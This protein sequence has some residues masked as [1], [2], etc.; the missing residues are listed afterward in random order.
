M[1]RLTIA[2]VGAL[3]LSASL[4]LWGWSEVG[5]ARTERD[6]AND[7]ARASL[8]RLQA[9]QSNL[10]RV[11]SDSATSELRLSQV[12]GTLPDARTPDAVY[13]EL[14]ARANCAKLDP[15]SAPAD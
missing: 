14:C 9:V 8:E 11:K 15:L 4:A 7:A 1:S 12:L 3:L 6:T 2:L 13:N 5:T 10:R